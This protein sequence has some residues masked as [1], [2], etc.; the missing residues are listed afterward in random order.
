MIQ[1]FLYTHDIHVAS[2]TAPSGSCPPARRPA[3]PYRLK[4]FFSPPGRAGWG[5]GEN[6]GVRSL[7]SL[8]HCLSAT[9]GTSALWRF[10]AA[11]GGKGH[12]GA[13][14]RGAAALS[15]Y[16]KSWGLL[17]RLTV[18]LWLFAYA[19]RSARTSPAGTCSTGTAVAPRHAPGRTLFIGYRQ[20]F[21]ALAVRGGSRRK[22]PR[23][24]RKDG[25][26]WA[27]GKGKEFGLASSSLRFHH[28]LCSCP[29]PCSPPPLRPSLYGR[30]GCAPAFA[31]AHIVFRLPPAPPLP[32]AVAPLPA[33]P[34][35]LI[36]C[37]LSFPRPGVRAG[38]LE[39]KAVSARYA[40]SHIVCRLPLS[41]PLP[42]A[43]WRLAA[44]K[45]T[46]E[47]AGGVRLHYRRTQ[48]AGGCFIVLRSLCGS[49]RTP[50]VPHAPL[51]LA[52]ALRAQRLRPGI[53]PGAHCFSA[54]ASTSA[55]W[56]FAAARGSLVTTTLFRLVAA[57]ATCALLAA[58]L[59]IVTTYLFRSTV[60][61]AIVARMGGLCV[62]RI[63]LGYRQHIR[64]QRVFGGSRQL[65]AAKKTAG[66]H[67]NPIN[68]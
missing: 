39:K 49:L 46:Q 29:P 66:T 64:S 13:S 47:P 9:A 68:V 24:S 7:R 59:F 20:H 10:A 15:A 52:P 43:P 33:S 41:P 51:L 60:R 56:R 12:A 17:H 31:R 62:A 34:P 36:G 25:G 54:T 40:R 53:R 1:A 58:P 4:P 2:P 48:R 6:S 65:S 42:A 23:D 22:R 11:R 50:T 55:L 5:A 67:E 32:A 45:A 37:D 21:R 30:S 28:A 18:S 14:R 26:G 27:P 38:G 3:R 44:E 61:G 35:T 8:P 16:A 19:Y 63:Y 57:W